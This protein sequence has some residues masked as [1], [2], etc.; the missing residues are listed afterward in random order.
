MAD[1]DAIP[2]QVPP[3]SD[4]AVRPPTAPAPPCQA[5][6]PLELVRTLKIELIKATSAAARWQDRATDL[7]QRL[8]VAEQRLAALEGDQ[9]ARSKPHQGA[10]QESAQDDETTV[11]ATR[12]QAE[13]ARTLVAVALTPVLTPLTTELTMLRQ[14]N[15]ALVELFGDLR[16]ERGRL[17]AELEHAQALMLEQQAVQPKR[18]SGLITRDGVLIVGWSMAAITALMLGL[19][20]ASLTLMSMR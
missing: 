11:P 1:G 16:E 2:G 19:G 13:A 9:D 10:P 12:A 5:D 17:S 6:E 14:E 8:A 7:A 20:I 18:A 4:D 15:E 3:P